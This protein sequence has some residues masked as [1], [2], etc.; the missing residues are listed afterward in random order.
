[1]IALTS[2]TL[3]HGDA[4]RFSLT[5]PDLSVRA[6]EKIALIGPSGVGK[7]TM[8]SAL[9]GLVRPQSG[10]LQVAGVDL[11]NASDRARRRLR[12]GQGLI[13]QT[14]ALVPYLDVRANALLPLRLRGDAVDAAVEA[15]VTALLHRIGLGA[16]ADHLPA[17]LSRGEQQR[18]AI[19]RALLPRPALI[20]A[21]EPTAALDTAATA[22][23]MDLIFEWM[24]TRG[25][26]IM[27][28]HDPSLRDSFDRVLDLA[29][30]GT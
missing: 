12:A 19:C 29:E 2:V 11:S 3:A 28:T 23:V 30:W 25:T 6:G 1:M 27:A 13:L 15:R 20:L 8:L 18:V 10:T 17:A 4:G 26:L 24:G 7:S 16:R 5:P 9:A 21:D 22:Q 14:P